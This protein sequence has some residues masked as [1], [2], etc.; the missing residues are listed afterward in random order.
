MREWIKRKKGHSKWAIYLSV[1]LVFSSSFLFSHSLILSLSL[2][3]SLTLSLSII[4]K[5]LLGSHA[6]SSYLDSRTQKGKTDRRALDL[7]KEQGTNKWMNQ[8]TRVRTYNTAYFTRTRGLAISGFLQPPPPFF[9]Y[10]REK[11][12]SG[13]PPLPFHYSLASLSPLTCSF[14]SYSLS[15][16]S[17]RSPFN[18]DTQDKQSMCLQYDWAVKRGEG[19]QRGGCCRSIHL[20]GLMEIWEKRSGWWWDSRWGRNMSHTVIYWSFSLWFPLCLFSSY[21]LFGFRD[22]DGCWNIPW[23]CWNMIEV[24]VWMTGSLCVMSVKVN[25]STIP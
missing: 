17:F 22:E 5:W 25:V 15:L 9:L 13:R 3:L 20:I 4:T 14:F 7:T 2:S 6:S 21:S 11:L 23:W 12:L 18:F 24:L 10:S 19:R 16:S 8:R 1:E